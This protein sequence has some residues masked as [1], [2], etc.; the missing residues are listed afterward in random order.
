MRNR[1]LVLFFVSSPQRPWCLWRK[2]ACS[3]DFCALFMASLPELPGPAP[4]DRRKHII[5]SKNIK[6]RTRRRYRLKRREVHSRPVPFSSDLTS[7]AGVCLEFLSWSFCSFELLSFPFLSSHS[8]LSFLVLSF[9]FFFPSPSVALASVFAS[10]SSFCSTFF[11]SWRRNN[12]KQQ[13]HTNCRLWFTVG[14]DELHHRQSSV[15]PDYVWH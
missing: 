12:Q 9:P 10:L 1:P 11:F 4:F 6:N 8:F 5:I 14:R 7:S 15:I 2:K 13:R 3:R